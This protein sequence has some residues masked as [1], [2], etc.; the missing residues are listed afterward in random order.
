MRLVQLGCG[1]TGLVC[2]E[3]LESNEDVNEI[4]LADIDPDPAKE[5]TKR[6]KSDKFSVTQVDAR[7][8]QALRKLL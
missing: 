5:M 3:L 2:A 4:V 8:R 1:I 7:D 6:V